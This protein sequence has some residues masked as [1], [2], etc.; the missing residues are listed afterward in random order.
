M[1]RILLALL[2]A[3]ALVVGIAPSASAVTCCVNVV[4]LKP[5]KGVKRCVWGG[6][7]D[8]VFIEVRAAT[9]KTAV[10]RAAKVMKNIRSAKITPRSVDVYAY[11]G[12]KR[13]LAKTYKP[14]GK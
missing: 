7:P 4:E 1:R 8:S 13:V 10:A 2:T 5:C 9:K 6:D 3:V 14:V 12:R 11:K